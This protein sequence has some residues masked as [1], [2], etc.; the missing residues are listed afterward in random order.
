MVDSYSI[1]YMY[2]FFIHSCLDGHFGCFQVLAIVHGAAVHV[3]VH[4]F[5]PFWILVYVLLGTGLLDHMISLVLPCKDTTILFSIVAFNHF[6]PTS[7]IG[8]FPFSMPSPP[9]IFCRP[10]DDGHSDWDEVKPHSSFDMHV[11][12]NSKYWAS[13]HVLSFS[14]KP[15][16]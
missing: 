9:F 4:V 6:H 12:S 14:F 15:S 16:E 11:S 1:P 13:F 10:F 7:T 5:F 2:H 3:W 8:R